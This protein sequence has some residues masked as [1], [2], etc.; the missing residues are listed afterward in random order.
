MMKLVNPRYFKIRA[1]AVH[2]YTSL[3]LIMALLAMDAVVRG[4]VQNAFIWLGAAMFI[5]ATDGT[6]ARSWQVL[7]WA[8]SFDGR[9][10]D[11]IIDY[12]TYGF[13]PL[14]MAYRFDLVEKGFWG[15]AALGIVLISAA[16]GFCRKTAKTNDGYF[17]GFPNYWNF[18]VFYMFLLHTP[19]LVNTLGLLFFAGLVFVPVQYLSYSS[20]PLRRVSVVMSGLYGIILLYLLV[21]LEDASLLPVLISMVFPLY[22]LIASLVIYMNRRST[23]RRDGAWIEEA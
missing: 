2:L 18:L 6:L 5:D 8:P 17:T 21:H 15:L 11:D 20:H 23:L 7:V 13:I 22:Y 9:K 4:N 10:L 1:W 12:M 3:G 16:Y 19:P 14:F